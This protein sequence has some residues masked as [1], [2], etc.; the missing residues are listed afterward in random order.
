MCSL[1]LEYTSPIR[2]QD[3]YLLLARLLLCLQEF[4]T[5]NL[6]I[7]VQGVSLNALETMGKCKGFIITISDKLRLAATAIVC[8][9]IEKILQIPSLPWPRVLQ[10]SFW[11][12]QET[13]IFDPPELGSI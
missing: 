13:F 2:L 1:N 10:K 4:C 11:P 5:S 6:Y 8:I 3:Q 12:G 9:E 7:F